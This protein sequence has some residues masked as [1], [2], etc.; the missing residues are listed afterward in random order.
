VLPALSVRA[1]DSARHCRSCRIRQ[2]TPA[3]T[4]STQPRRGTRQASSAVVAP[5]DLPTV[6]TPNWPHRRLDRDEAS[7]GGAGRSHDATATLSACS[8]PQPHPAKVVS[9]ASKNHHGRAVRRNSMINLIYDEQGQ[10]GTRAMTQGPN[11]T[12][13]ASPDWARNKCSARLQ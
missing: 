7:P 4:R 10:M 2:P 5:H 11:W 3:L 6:T 9:C 1:R 13:R 8:W 12:T